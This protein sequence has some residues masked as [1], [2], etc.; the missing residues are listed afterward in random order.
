M[1][2]IITTEEILTP[3]E[4]DE[5]VEFL[6]EANSKVGLNWSPEH[7]HVLAREHGRVI[8][9]LVGATNWQWLY[10]RLLAVDPSAR[11]AGIGTKLME[12]AEKEA[13]R[14]G[15]T[16]AHVDTF[17]FQALP[18]Y[19]KRGYTIFGQLPDYPETH[20]RYFLFK[21]LG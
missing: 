12:T 20:T 21:Q 11:A 5:I 18:F 2:T 14:R 17:S 3:E 1:S 13:Y 6:A 19:Q 7:I 10:I 16:H 9:G 15:C 4:T 8:G